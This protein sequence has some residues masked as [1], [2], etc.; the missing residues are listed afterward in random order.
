MLDTH[1]HID[2]YQNPLE[3][4]KEAENHGIITIAVTNLPSH[5]EMIYPYLSTFKRLRLALGL[6]PQLVKSGKTERII[7]ERM[8]S[9]TS[10]IGEIGL[11]FSGEGKFS[12]TPQIETLKF[13]LNKIQDRPRF[14]T[15]HSRK[16]ESA[17]LELLEEYNIEN[18]V[19]HWY[20]GPLKVLEQAIKSGHYFSLNHAMV[21][22]KKG[23]QIIEI[24]PLD[25]IL[26]E[27]DGPFIQLG[28]REVTPSDIKTLLI[29]LADIRKLPVLEIENHI[30]SNFRRLISPIKLH[31][32]SKT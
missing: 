17:V 27:T 32:I 22:S 19:F 1:C 18:A 14:I 20:S 10:Y 7:F 23:R 11:D 5:F 3:V 9:K 25:C 16:A 2:H 31:N 12:K 28:S 21:R 26:T 6:H 8:L 24:I 4:A 13:I 29:A 30:N 15:L